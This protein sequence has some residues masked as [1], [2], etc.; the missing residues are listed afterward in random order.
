MIIGHQKQIKFLEKMFEEKRL[1]QALLFSGQ[2]KLGKKKIALEVASWLLGKNLRAHPDFILIES[3]QQK[4]GM[5]QIQINQIRE[6]SWRLSLKPMEASSIVGI[7]DN[8]HLMTIEAQNCFLK[9]L[10]EPR[11][12][13]ILILITPHPDFL[14]PTIL[15]RCQE[16]KF[17]PVKNAEISNFL[18]EKGI[19]GENLQKIVEISL[20]RPGVAIDFLKDPKK[21]EKRERWVKELIRLPKISLFERFQLAKELS[22]TDNLKEILESWLVYLRSLLIKKIFGKEVKNSYS[23]F[24]LK[25]IIEKI[26]ERI[27]FISTTN[28]NPRLALEELM[29]EF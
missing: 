22:E 23:L 10:E 1:P 21:M 12:K 19:S 20:G 18:K 8:A 16:I 25:E 24:K 28:I 13:S 7:I 5:S 17:Y 4:L 3:P 29:L 27:F 15:S 6:F 2:E 11:A 14:L 26:Q 9:T